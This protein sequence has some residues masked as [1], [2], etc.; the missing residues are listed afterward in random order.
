MGSLCSYPFSTRCEPDSVS[1]VNLGTDCDRLRSLSFPKFEDF[2]GRL[3]HVT[4]LPQSE[5]RL[6]KQEHLQVSPGS[7][8]WAGSRGED[9]RV[10][11]F[12]AF[13]IEMTG[14]FNT[15]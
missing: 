8:K 2:G 11:A 15:I 13:M 7:L 12:D 14:A 10:V 3:P 6:R 9:C 5:K 1:S 4:R